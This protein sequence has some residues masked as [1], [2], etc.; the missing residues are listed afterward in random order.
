M[1]L[2]LLNCSNISI[3]AMT[4]F[5]PLSLSVNMHILFSVLH[6]FPM[7][8]VERICTSINTFHVRCSFPFSRDLYV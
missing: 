1:T 5:N 6:I 7:V 3:Q 2:I 4:F 8:L